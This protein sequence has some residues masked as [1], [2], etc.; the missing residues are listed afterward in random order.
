MK[1]TK[2]PV[3]YYFYKIT[4]LIN[5]KKYIGS[6]KFQGDPRN[7]PYIGSGKYLQKD[8]QKYGKSSFVKEILNRVV[9]INRQFIL[10]QEAAFI[11]EHNTLS[12][13]G[14]NHYLP[15]EKNP[16]HTGGIKW[17]EKIRKNMSAG[18]RTFLNSEK[19]DA[20]R[21]SISGKNNVAKRPEVR[22]KLSK[23]NVMHNPKIVNKLRVPKSEET[24]N[25][26]SQTKKGKPQHSK[27]SEN[28][29]NRLLSYYQTEEGIARKKRHSE[30]MK[31]YYRKKKLHD[32]ES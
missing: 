10:Q 6:R 15:T 32:T 14:Y 18:R 20:Y 13:N 9:F 5:G 2:H 31:E 30:Y 21:K 19:G 29:S 26:I 8:I 22:E 11:I 3:F 7:D 4:C 27:F 1:R 24:K 28:Q 17:S 16:F 12:P 23:H 25:K